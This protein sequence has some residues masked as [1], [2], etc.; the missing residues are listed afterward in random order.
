MCWLALAP[1]LAG[2]TFYAAREPGSIKGIKMEIGNLKFDPAEFWV[3]VVADSEK[4]KADIVVWHPLF[5][6]MEQGKRWTVLFLFLDEVLGEYGTEQ[7][8]GEI[9]LEPTRLR[10][11]MPLEELGEAI[12]R[13]RV[14][15]G[16]KRLPPGEQLVGYQCREQHDR[17]LRG[18]VVTGTT[19]HPRLLNEYVEANGEMEDA[20]DGTGADYV[21]VAFDTQT[22]PADD[23]MSV[24]AKIEDSLD[25]ALKKSTCGRL[26]GGASG[27][28]NSYID[29]LI[30]DGEESNRIVQGVLLDQALP[31]GSSIN[32]FA[33]EK[34]GLKIVL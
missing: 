6:S 31:A 4:E 34:R 26:L 11:S 33:K 32:Y 14:A 30:F 1:R 16:W 29:L 28:V 24:R 15:S 5:D 13:I 10:D 23:A 3:S 17:F 12:H 7:W 8:I 2:W 25:Q 20:L 9:K 21:F 18:D 22:L 27:R 19:T